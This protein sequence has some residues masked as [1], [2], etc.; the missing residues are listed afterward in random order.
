MSRNNFWKQLFSLPVSRLT[1]EKYQSVNKNFF[2]KLNKS[3]TETVSLLYE[4]FGADGGV[5]AHKISGYALSGERLLWRGVYISMVV[6]LRGLICG[7]NKLVNEV[8]F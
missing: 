6:T 7:Y 5:I 3:S 1:K 8:S 2:F 4:V